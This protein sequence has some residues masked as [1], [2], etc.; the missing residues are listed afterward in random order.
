MKFLY[1]LD[2]HPFGCYLTGVSPECLGTS[3]ES[4]KLSLECIEASPE[5]ARTSP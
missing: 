3:P 4:V 5:K 2:I 1:K